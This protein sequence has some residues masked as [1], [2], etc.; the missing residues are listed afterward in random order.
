MERAALKRGWWRLS[1]RYEA[2]L[3]NTYNGQPVYDDCLYCGV[4]IKNLRYYPSE[5]G[6]VTAWFD[7]SEDNGRR[8]YRYVGKG[9]LPLEGS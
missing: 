1:E 7:A 4:I 2:T 5:Q 9:H 6:G 8:W 3:I